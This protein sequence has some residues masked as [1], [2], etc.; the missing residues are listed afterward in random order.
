MNLIIYFQILFSHILYTSF[1]RS[2][3]VKNN[4]ICRLVIKS[5]SDPDSGFPIGIHSVFQHK[6]ECTHSE[7]ES[8]IRCGHSY[9]CCCS[10]VVA[11]AAMKWVTSQLHYDEDDDDM[12]QI[13]A[14][15][16]LRFLQY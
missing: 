8:T 11:A 5:T 13:Y 4:L 7:E 3:E 14:S 16:R 12:K 10:S 9:C 2:C 1:T 6:Q 15:H